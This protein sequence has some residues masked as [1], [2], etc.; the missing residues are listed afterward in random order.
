MNNRKFHYTLELS[1]QSEI[2]IAKP[3]LK[4]SNIKSS[5]IEIRNEEDIDK[6]IDLLNQYFNKE[7]KLYIDNFFYDPSTQDDDEDDEEFDLSKLREDTSDTHL[8][9]TLPIFPGS[10]RAIQGLTEDEILDGEQQCMNTDA[11]YITHQSKIEGK[12]IM[13]NYRIL[14]LPN[15]KITASKFRKDFFVILIGHIRR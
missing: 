14:F 15:N 10:K 4:T 6:D 8:E 5:D 12:L 9:G 1:C 13:T 3:E 7:S 11:Y 2:D